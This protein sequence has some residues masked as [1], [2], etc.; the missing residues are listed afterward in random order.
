MATRH[1]E[2]AQDALTRRDPLRRPRD[3]DEIEL[4]THRD[5]VAASREI[6]DRVKVDPD[7]SVMFLANPILAL[8]VYGIRLGKELRHHVLHTLRHPP[9]LAARRA[10]LEASLEESLGAKPRPADPE[11]MAA[12]VFEM[13]EIAP[14]QV[15]ERKPA[16]R[17][18]LNADAVARLKASRPSGG[19][20]Y[21][22]P[23]RLPVRFTLRVAEGNE[24]IRRLDLDAPLPELARAAKAPKALTVEAAWFYKDDPIVRNAVELGQIMRRG[25]PFRTPAEFRKI[26]AGETVDAF[27]KFVT[28]IR[29]REIERR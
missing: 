6:A 2:A 23:R 5:L 9:K 1:P 20:K 13:R 19:E 24:T 16:Y 3:R 11:W 26:A 8:E 12:L 22:Q 25:F 17:P 18:A 15:G 28:G 4:K 21:A 14:R 10:E 29:L 27:R 7:F